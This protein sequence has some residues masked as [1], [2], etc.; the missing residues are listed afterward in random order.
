MAEEGQKIDLTENQDGGVIKVIKKE[1]HGCETPMKGVKVEVD[2]TGR[3]VDGTVFDSS[4]NHG[5]KFHFNLGKGNV[6]KAWDL[7]VASM[8]Q[9][10][11]CEVTCAA[12]YAYGKRGSPPK[13]PPNATLI[14]EIELY[15]WEGEDITEEQDGGILKE[16]IEAGTDGDEANEGATVDVSVIGKFQ[17]KVFD[18]RRVKFIVDED[19][20]N[21]ISALPLAIKTMKANERCRIRIKP[22]YAFGDNGDAKFNI[23]PNSTVQYEITMNSLER[24]RESWQMTDEERVNESLKCKEKGTLML[25]EGKFAKAVKLYN[26]TVDI[27]NY[28][29][30][31]ET[32][33][34]EDK[35]LIKKVETIKLAGHLNLALCHNKT[36][37]YSEVIHICDK[38]LSIDACNEKALY[39][40]GE[41]QF[42]ENN[43]LEAK[44]SFEMAY[45][46]SVNNKKANKSAY[47]YLQKCKI[48]VKNQQE[49]ERSTF[50]GMFDKFVQQDEREEVRKKIKVQEEKAKMKAEKKAANAN[51]NGSCGEP[52]ATGDAVVMS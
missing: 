10:E 26:R 24:C 17:D 14:F 47:D 45:R 32:G 40:K 36:K 22:K 52:G 42:F 48:Q 37:D 25:K 1:G 9:G 18:E 31:K 5:S 30:A 43:F 15:S 20:D 19:D 4:H 13:I 3:L 8:K 39:R 21:L 50:A 11:V 34:D 2:Y 16:T 44:S 33:S 29:D 41:A 35:A 38:A 51:D 7:C 12:K 28:L 6:I 27:V 23:P 46:A 49:R